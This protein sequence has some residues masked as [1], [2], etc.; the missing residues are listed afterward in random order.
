M[1]VGRLGATIHVEVSV[2]REGRPIDTTGGASS[3]LEVR[4]I[5][6]G[7]LRDDVLQWLGPFDDELEERQDRYLVAAT[8]DLSVKIRGGTQL[9]LKVFRGSPGTL[10]TPV[11]VRGRLEFWERWSFPLGANTL[12]LVDVPAWLTIEKVRRRRSFRVEHGHVYGRP[13]SDAGLPG[14]TIE[15]TEIA[16]DAETWWTVGLEARGLP[17]TLGRVM[18]LTAERVFRGPSPDDIRLDVMDSMSYATW[19]GRRADRAAGRGTDDP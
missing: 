4:W 11:A 15:L 14:C 12:P 1:S 13:V 3:T 8:P 10:E 5:R 17:Q 2:G 18:E 16:T 19:L 9:D 7:T 6:P